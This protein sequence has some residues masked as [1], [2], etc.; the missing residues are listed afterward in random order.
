M[1]D[2]QGAAEHIRA[3]AQT[4]FNEGRLDLLHEF[5]DGR[6]TLRNLYGDV[7]VEGVGDLRQHLERWLAAFHEPQL[8]VVD[9]LV[10][11]DR[12]AWQWRLDTTD[13]RHV[14]PGMPG[15]GAVSVNGVTFSSLLDGRIIEECNEADVHG[16]LQQ[17]GVAP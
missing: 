4:I 1:T 14:T 13:H 17:I 6:F 2:R 12:V 10:E 15:L 3:Y 7:L 5:V 16:Y 8:T 11:G 9:M